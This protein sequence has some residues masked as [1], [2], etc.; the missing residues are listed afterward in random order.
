MAYQGVF[1]SRGKIIKLAEISGADLIGTKVSP[2]FGVYPEVYVLPMDGVLAT[3]GTGVVTCVPSDSPDD[4]ATLMDLRKKAEYYGIK[5]EWAR[6]DPLPVISTPKYG[7]MIA[8]T[9][10]V[11]MKIQSQKDKVKLAEAK[12]IAYKEGFYSGTMIYGD[13]KGDSVEVA[14]PKVRQQLIDSKLAFAYAEPENV[15]VS[16]SGDEC[17]VALCD[18]WYLDYGAAEWKAKAELWVVIKPSTLLSPYSGC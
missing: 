1:E 12:D 8:K 16:R 18:Q 10:V 13:F 3:K 17:I 15:V 5:P 14:K 4:Y 6:F 9:L 2:A 7:D 11:D